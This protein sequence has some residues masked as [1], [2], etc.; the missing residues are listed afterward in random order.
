MAQLSIFMTS[1]KPELEPV[2]LLDQPKIRRIQPPTLY[3]ENPAEVIDTS[4]FGWTLLGINDAE[5][6]NRHDMAYF[7]VRYAKDQHGATVFRQGRQVR[8]RSQVR[9]WPV[10]NFK[11]FIFEIVLPPSEGATLVICSAV[12]L[13]VL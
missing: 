13:A 4:V 11:A 8:E 12:F 9:Q 1:A 5:P 3:F 10:L 6:I 7:P 2:A